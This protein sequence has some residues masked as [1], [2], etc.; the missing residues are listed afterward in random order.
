M[1]DDKNLKS[2]LRA[3]GVHAEFVTLDQDV[4]GVLYS[5]V[6]PNEKT[7]IAI[8]VMH[9]NV[10]YLTHD[11][12]GMAQFGY[13]VLCA[14]VA[15]Q[16]LLLD[17]RLRNVQAAMRFLRGAPG[18]QRVVLWGHS[19]GAT[20]LSAYQLIAENGPAVCQGPEKLHPCSGDLDDLL[21]ADGLMLIDANWG[22][23]VMMLLSLDPALTDEDGAA[24]LDPSLDLFRPENGF[25]PGGSSFPDAFIRRFQ[26]AQG[27]RSRR[28]IARAQQR[29]ARLERGEAFYT[30]DEPFIVPGAAQ[31]FLNNKLFAQ[32]VRLVAHTAAPHPLLHADGSVT[33][34]VVPSLRRPANDVSF[35]RS[36]YEG[37]LITTLRNFLAEFAVRTA[38]DYGYDGSRLYGVDWSSLRL[39]REQRLGHPRAHA[40]DGHDRGLGVHR[41]GEHLRAQRQ[42]RQVHL[43]CRGRAA[44]L[45]DRQGLRGLPRPVR[46]HARPHPRPLRRLARR[47]RP[48]PVTPFSRKSRAFARVHIPR[49]FRAC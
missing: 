13:T 27:Q 7:R 25:R 46:R 47:A 28:L 31:G 10:D 3:M 43:L 39:A 15:S 11:I 23:A 45:Q 22:N 6:H 9:S 33:H 4:R 32:D 38:E 16:Y 24:A 49:P 37:A 1:T 19:G 2:T 17:R 12:L 26:R 36:F 14:N 5:P 21:P 42:Q 18:V 34:G 8:L 48:L 41:L 20:L 44:H 29:L 30:D 40:C 35:T